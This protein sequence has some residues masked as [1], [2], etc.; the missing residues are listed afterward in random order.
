[1]NYAIKTKIR[2][3]QAKMFEFAAQKTM[4]GAKHVAEG[5][6]IFLFAS[7]NEGGHGLV[8]RGV[9]TSAEAIPRKPGVE[10]Q[11]PR[12]SVAIERA[13]L[14]KRALGRKELKD[15]SD[16]ND[17]RPETELNFKL[18]RQTT[19]KIVGVSDEAAAFLGE[20]F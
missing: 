15:F 16:W 13:A 3:P 4:Y 18:Y 6:S 9:V 10:R 5:D 17:G 8:A 14:A 7:E 11:T 20:F 1:M 2:N 12:V 19:N